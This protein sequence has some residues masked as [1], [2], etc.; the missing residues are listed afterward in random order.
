MT[1]FKII[2]DLMG[3]NDLSKNEVKERLDQE[4]N[5]YGYM[6]RVYGIEHMPQISTIVKLSITDTLTKAYNR[7]AFES[8]LEEEISKTKRYKAPLTLVIFGVDH[9]R[10]INNENGSLIGNFI[11]IELADVVKQRIRTSDM[12]FRWNGDEFLVI[13]PHTD[14]NGGK[15]MV[16]KIEEDIAKFNFN[17]IGKTLSCS[18]GISE[19]DPE[20]DLHDFVMKVED[21]LHE[22]KANRDRGED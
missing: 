11:L 12:L 16:E 7:L 4:F 20:L 9:F 6:K 8:F 3:G 21:S 17:T 19:Y 22:A 15:I 13:V 10:K 14:I 18:F 5:G 1:I 2:A